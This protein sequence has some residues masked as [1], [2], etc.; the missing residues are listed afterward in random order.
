MDNLLKVRD[1]KQIVNEGNE[2][3]HHRIKMRNSIKKN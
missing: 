2:F 1:I 3:Y